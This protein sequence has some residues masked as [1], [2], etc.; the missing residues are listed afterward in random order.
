MVAEKIDRNNEL[1]AFYL[2]HYGKRR[3]GEIPVLR[4][5]TISAIGRKFGV[6]S[7]V[8]WRIIQRWKVKHEGKD[9]A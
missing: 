4:I 3:K 5:W 1:Y 8:A 6:R 9:A 2:K 7:E